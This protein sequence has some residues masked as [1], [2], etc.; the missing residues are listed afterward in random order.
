MAMTRQEELEFFLSG[1]EIK[2][3]GEKNKY[4][5]SLK[6]EKQKERFVDFI[7]D[8]KNKNKDTFEIFESFFKK[9]KKLENK[10]KEMVNE[11]EKGKLAN[12]THKFRE[13][14]KGSKES[15]EYYKTWTENS[16]DGWDTLAIRDQGKG[17]FYKFK[18][19][20][21]RARYAIYMDKFG[22]NFD[23]KVDATNRFFEVDKLNRQ[24]E[25][26]TEMHQRGDYALG[27]IDESFKDSQFKK[28]DMEF[29]ERDAG[30]ERERIMDSAKHFKELHPDL[31]KEIDKISKDRLDMLNKKVDGYYKIS[32]EIGNE[33]AKK[34]LEN[35]KIVNTISK[36][37][38]PTPL[39]QSMKQNRFGGIGSRLVANFKKHFE[40]AIDIAR[41]IQMGQQVM[42]MPKN[43]LEKAGK[44]IGQAR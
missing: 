27:R 5:F 7:S 41:D 16:H 18:N 30:Y 38:A 3:A 11:Q 4:I 28:I 25:I 39:A 26:A 2:Y 21:Q 36:E 35:F 1:G 19:T 31:K 20:D 24:W 15:K 22:N 13:T 33:F 29:L 14:I 44:D 12:E 34:N 32:F 42:N 9:E 8:D 37:K 6:D 23:N 17:G 43:A 10:E 40:K